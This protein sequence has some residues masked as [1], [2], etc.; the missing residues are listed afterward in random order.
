MLCVIVGCSTPSTM[1]DDDASVPIDAFRAEDGAPPR[2]AS[3]DAGAPPDGPAPMD[4]GS[5]APS[6]DAW[7][8]PP[9]TTDLSGQPGELLCTGLRASDADTLEATADIGRDELMPLLVFVDDG[10]VYLQVPIRVR[11]ICGGGTGIPENGEPWSGALSVEVTVGDVPTPLTID[12]EPLVVE[13]TG[14]GDYVRHAFERLR[15][16]YLLVS[17]VEMADNFEAARIGIEQAQMAGGTAVFGFGSSGCIPAYNCDCG[18]AVMWSANLAAVDA[19]LRNSWVG[20]TA[21]ELPEGA[22]GGEM[23][24]LARC[25]GG[26]GAALRCALGFAAIVILADRPTDSFLAAT[27]AVIYAAAAFTRPIENLIG[28]AVGLGRHAIRQFEFLSGQGAALRRTTYR[29]IT[30]LPSAIMNRAFGTVGFSED[31]IACSDCRT[32]TPDGATAMAAG[33]GSGACVGYADCGCTG[34]FG[35]RGYAPGGGFCGAC[36]EAS[37][38]MPICIPATCVYENTWIELPV[39]CPSRCTSAMTP[40]CR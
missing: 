14:G 35:C 10:N 1:T 6:V 30:G 22:G 13:A 20:L 39:D 28:S 21:L 12:V 11:R 3:A 32:P 16:E 27:G 5:D 2:D 17:D 29:T 36:V 9:C 24:G 15:D 34:A 31:E 7:T 33:C 18:P 25:D 8:P 37:P 23:D 38:G 4:A 19:F 26:S 40:A